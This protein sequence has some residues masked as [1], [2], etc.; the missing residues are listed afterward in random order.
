MVI[1]LLPSYTLDIVY[2]VPLFVEDSSMKRI[3]IGYYLN[4]HFLIP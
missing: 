2:L 1:I 4:F 3:A